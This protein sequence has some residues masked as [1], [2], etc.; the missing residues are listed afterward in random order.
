MQDLISEQEQ[1][2]QEM[3]KISQNKSLS[4][5]DKVSALNSV[6][7]LSKTIEDL[8]GR[9]KMKISGLIESKLAVSKQQSF[10]LNNQKQSPSY[11]DSSNELKKS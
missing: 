11:S 5:H 9:E 8:L 6:R 10:N 7:S 4:K 2:K 3:L 1:A